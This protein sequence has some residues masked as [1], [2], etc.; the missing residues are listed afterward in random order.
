MHALVTTAPSGDE[1]E[2]GRLAARF[3]LRCE[4]RQ[5]R[6]I[7]EL[8][9]AAE[10]APV[11]ILGSRRADLYQGTQVHRASPG[12]AYLRVLRAGQGEVDPLV[13]AAALVAGD[14]VL[15]CTLGLGGDALV[16]SQ[17]VGPEGLVVA[18]EKSPVLA[19][20]TSA[21]YARA[22]EPAAAA[23]ARIEV[24]AADHRAVL[25]AL[26]SHSFDVVLLDPMFRAPLDAGPLFPLLRA[27]A[28]H[29][30]LSEGDL[31][32]ARRVARRGVLVKDAWPGRELHRLGLSALPSR[33]APKIVFGWGATN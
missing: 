2:A 3:G 8:L 20:F 13:R 18:L 15:D 26:P 22:P 21:G 28:D 16:A 7:P 6:L 25:A 5:G 1:A 10:G 32:E 24:H 33:R 4:G 29:A 30:P 12:M 23:A 19:A 11:L 17:A 27:H 31:L 14:R 9:A